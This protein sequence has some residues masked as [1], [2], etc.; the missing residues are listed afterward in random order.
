MQQVLADPEL[1]A[2]YDDAEVM[3]AV[4]DIAAHP[5]HAARHLADPKV[6]YSRSQKEVI[7][8]CKRQKLRACLS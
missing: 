6:S 8:G 1:M 4:A 7:A 3:A 5:Q 2:G